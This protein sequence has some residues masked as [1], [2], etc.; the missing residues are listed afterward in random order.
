MGPSPVPSRGH[1]GA[2]WWALSPSIWVKATMTKTRVKGSSIPAP[3]SMISMQSHFQGWCANE[4]GFSTL[5]SMRQL[6]LLTNLVSSGI[7]SKICYLLCCF[8][9]L[10]ARTLWGEGPSPAAHSG[11][12]NGPGELSPGLSVAGTALGKLTYRPLGNRSA[13]WEEM[14]WS[15]FIVILL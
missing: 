2:I 14:S 3:N 15:P 1:S 5:K 9:A 4:T 11:W 13:G 6:F 12:R 10:L 8:S 7:C